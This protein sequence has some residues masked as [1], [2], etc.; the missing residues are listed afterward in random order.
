MQ[1]I[2][3]RIPSVRKEL[4]SARQEFP[5]ARQEFLQ[6]NMDALQQHSLYITVYL[7]YLCFE[8]CMLYSRWLKA[9]K[10]QLVSEGKSRKLKTDLLGDNIQ[11]DMIPLLFKENDEHVY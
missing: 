6:Q 11:S 8:M 7:L 3:I 5:L 2:K 9:Y 1:F 4:E 10:V